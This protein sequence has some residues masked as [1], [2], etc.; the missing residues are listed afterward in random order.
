M[1][2]IGNDAAVTHGGASGVFELNVAI[3]LMA[4]ALLE[5]IQL[6][7]NGCMAFV[8]KCLE[9]IEADED[10]CSDLIAGSLMLSTALVNILINRLLSMR[11][12]IDS[13]L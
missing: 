1:R 3:P 9:G 7:S 11:S 6:Q 5:S 13:L 2:V 12:A 10:R 4:D 8:E